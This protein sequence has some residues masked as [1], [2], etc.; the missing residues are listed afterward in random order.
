LRVDAVSELES[1][2]ER[3]VCFNTGGGLAAVWLNGEKIFD[4][5][6]IGGGIGRQAGA[7]R[8]PAT[9][10]EGTNRIVIEAGD[11][12]FLSVTESREW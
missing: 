4:N 3:E 12:F 1:T 2:E 6:D 11:S 9:L 8:I 5:D 7:Q 10:R